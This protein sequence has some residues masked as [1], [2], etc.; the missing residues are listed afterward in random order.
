MS[1]SASLT[2]GAGEGGITPT[3]VETPTEQQPTSPAFPEKF[4]N[5]DGSQNVEAMLAAYEALEKKLGSQGAPAPAES[6]VAEEQPP[7]APEAD[8][9]EPSQA[10][11]EEPAARY[12]DR[13]SVQDASAY[14]AE[15]GALADEHYAAL[16][17][18][19]FNKRTVDLYIQGMQADAASFQS[20]LHGELNTNADGYANMIEFAGTQSAEFSK[21][22]NDAV[23]ADDRPAI[24]AEAAKMWKAY[25]E[26]EGQEPSTVV[27]G[28]TTPSVERFASMAEQ[29]R[30]QADP[31]YAK[32]PAY[33]AQVDAKIARSRY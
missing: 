1:D 25:I 21:A 2:I 27:S 19:G 9:P 29:R 22:Y 14:Y 15:N 8:D 11:P 20:E 23:Q 33:R 7:A 4:L 17:A 31:R 3:P 18:E 28:N 10:A 24:K 12:E 5:E 30:A 6:P 32:D 16:E 13:K 26:S